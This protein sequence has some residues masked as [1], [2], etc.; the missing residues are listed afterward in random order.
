MRGSRTPFETFLIF[1]KEA[2]YGFSSHLIGE[3]CPFLSNEGIL[4]QSALL[5]LL[6]SFLLIRV[7]HMLFL[8]D[9]LAERLKI[10]V[11]FPRTLPFY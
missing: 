3:M 2:Q 9:D 4:C 8:S 5:S 1:L 7:V 11:I 6:L 10:G